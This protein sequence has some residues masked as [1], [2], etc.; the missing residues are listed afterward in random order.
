MI[1]FNEETRPKQK[2][3]VCQ[4]CGITKIFP[5]MFQIKQHANGFKQEKYCYVCVGN[6]Y[7]EY[8]IEEQDIDLHLTICR[9]EEDLINTL[10]HYGG[11]T[12]NLEDSKWSRIDQLFNEY[13]KLVTQ[14]TSIPAMKEFADK[15]RNWAFDQVGVRR[16][17]GPLKC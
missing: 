16:P 15:Y 14:N 6:Y 9:A 12:I 1:I 5:E 7:Q 2:L 4:M 3:V 8:K 13:K 17:E 10:K 11:D